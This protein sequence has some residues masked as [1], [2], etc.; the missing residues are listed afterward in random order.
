MENTVTESIKKE[1]ENRIED[2]EK[3]LDG[4]VLTIFSP[5]IYGI[6]TRVRDAIDKID[7]KRK[8]LFIILNTPGGIAACV[9]G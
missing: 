5:I 1:L 8:K 9:F 3:T 4:D 7:S 2:L 6:D